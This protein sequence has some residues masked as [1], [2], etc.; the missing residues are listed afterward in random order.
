MGHTTCPLPG[1]SC[2]V[3]RSCKSAPS[4]VPLLPLHVRTF[5]SITFARSQ[6]QSTQASR[7]RD[8]PTLLAIVIRGHAGIQA[9]PETERS[10]L[11]N[12]QAGRRRAS[13]A[14]PELAKLFADA[15]ADEVAAFSFPT[16]WTTWHATL[17]PKPGKDRCKLSGW[18][19]I[20]IQVCSG[21]G[22]TTRPL[23][24]PSCDVPRSCKSAPSPVPLPP[25]SR[26]Y[27]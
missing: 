15:C 1:S 5:E 6:T 3:P 13:Q 21:V 14:L 4:P 16:S 17:I 27:V 19:E 20:W 11:S 12:R 25:P 24:G 8:T 22:H 26:P 23:P 7:D 9:R 18:R 10:S 2:D